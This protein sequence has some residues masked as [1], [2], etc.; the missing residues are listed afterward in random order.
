MANIAGKVVITGAPSGIRGEPA[1]MLVGEEAR[2]VLGAHC[3]TS[4]LNL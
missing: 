4:G 1:R 2:V 3:K